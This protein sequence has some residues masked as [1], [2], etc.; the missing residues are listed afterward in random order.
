MSEE[1]KSC[2]FCGSPV[3]YMTLFTGMKM[4]YCKNRRECGAVVSFDN[5][6]CNNPH[7]DSARIAAWN[8]GST[9]RT[10]MSLEQAIEYDEEAAKANESLVS[11]H[12]KENRWI[13]NES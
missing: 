13:S 5:H 1:L 11:N 12:E 3:V 8:P 2:P 4:F 9:V 10:M 6:A 7:N